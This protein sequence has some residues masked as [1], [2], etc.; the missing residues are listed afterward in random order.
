M[1]TD[2]EQFD[3]WAKEIDEAN[4]GWKILWPNHCTKCEGAGGFYDPGHREQP[5]DF[6]ICTCVEAGKCPR[7]AAQTLPEE[8]EV[9]CSVCGWNWGKGKDDAAP[10]I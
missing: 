8:E 4:K 5:P 6:D 1:A 3:A 10:Q 9:P 7:C 2:E